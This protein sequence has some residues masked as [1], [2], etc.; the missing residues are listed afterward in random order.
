MVKGNNLLLN[1]FE[2]SAAENDRFT[3]LKKPFEN[4]ERLFG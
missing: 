3:T 2:W 4:F 1:G